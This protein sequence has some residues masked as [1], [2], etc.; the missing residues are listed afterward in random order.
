ML[1]KS[2]IKLVLVICLTVI[3]FLSNAQEMLG[4]T[5]G[6]YKGIAGTM[7]N[8][9]NMT[10]N[11]VFLDINIASADVFIRNNFAYIPKE[12][13]IIYDLF[14]NGY[15]FPTYGDDQRS[16]LYYSNT[17]NK[18]VNSNIR[19]MGPSV[20]LQV[21]D[22][23]F[24]ITTG[25][26]VIVSSNKIPYSVA[27]FAY[28]G[29][30]Y[31]A[32]QNQD[33]SGKN[34]DAVT[35]SWMEVGLS[36][37]YDIWKYYDQQLTVGLSVKKLWG[38][39]GGYTYAT[40]LNYNVPNDST[41]DI[42][43]LNAKAGFSAPINYDNM[44]FLSG[45]PTFRGSG[46]GLDVG[47]VYVKKKEVVMN[48]WRGGKLCSQKFDDY[49]YKI[50]VSILDIGRVKYKDNAQLHTYDDISIYWE[51]VDTL[52]FDN[53]NSFLAQIS[54]TFYGDPNASFESNQIKVGLPAALSIQAD[55]K[56]HKSIYV[57]GFFI[58]PIRF[59]LNTL[60]RPAQLA[61]IPRYETKYLEV[62]VPISLYDYKYPRIGLAARFYFITIGTERLGTYLGMADMNG[63][64][65]YASIKI[66]IN[67][68]SCKKKFGG[69]CSNND[70]GNKYW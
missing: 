31:D 65:I 24:G 39:A 19:L 62:S 60:R 58:H 15:Q 2:G 34:V 45:S 57:A 7:V 14:K 22:H 52:G 53:M 5:M 28:H 37:A 48:R 50:G 70:F 51:N 43:D 29:L 21:G 9:A 8:P 27:E 66:G 64:D 26:R 12:D 67:K 59:N 55:M 56:F 11:K 18:H 68:N 61:V 13:F 54:N 35:N 25:A 49:I 46:V 17:K 40:N 30:E 16:I 3:P 1:N 47:V 20:M 33:F 44:D 41:I 6:N 32:L 38:Y 63:L 4:L 69:A 42:Q 10:T 36:Y 23:A